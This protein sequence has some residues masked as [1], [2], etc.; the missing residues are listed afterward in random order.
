MSV[1]I[2][3]GTVHVVLFSLPECVHNGIFKHRPTLGA[4]IVFAHLIAARN[5]RKT[6][7]LSSL[8]HYTNNIRTGHQLPV[9]RRQYEL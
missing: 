5:Q 3:S 9:L 1:L 2:R 7:L 4:L 6:Y 8:P